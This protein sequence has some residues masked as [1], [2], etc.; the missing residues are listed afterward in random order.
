MA[1]DLTPYIPRLLV[2]W[3]HE[4]PDARCREIP[5]TLVFADISGFTAMSERLAR[6][7]KQ[8]AEEV[9]EIL[10]GNFARLLAA[11]YEEGGSLL[12]FG[13]DA[14]LLFFS[15]DEHAVAGCRAVIEMRRRLREGGRLRSSVGLI[16]LR[17]SAGVHSGNIEFFLAGESHR[18]L[19]IT[20]PAASAVV[21]MESA[22]SAGQILVSSGTL[23]ELPPGCVGDLQGGGFLLKR[24]P[25]SSGAARSA[26][27]APEPSFDAAL[28]VPTAIRRHLRASVHESEH[29]QV[30]VAFVHFGGIDGLI[31]GEGIESAART[32]DGLMRVVQAAAEEHEVCV[33]G[34]DIDRDGGKIILTSGAPLSARVTMRSGCCG[35]CGRL[36][37]AGSARCCASV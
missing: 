36:S 24:K 8:G 10:D 37:T 27:V 22:A 29:R 16:S 12:K 17:M 4:T 34:S 18:E 33:L 30:T 31:R 23:S 5:G 9:T 15:G 11:A 21:A 26:A 32:L 7:G 25:P 13:G 2:E 14:L 28:Y 20:G 19:M 3:Q 35:R 1:S 6:T